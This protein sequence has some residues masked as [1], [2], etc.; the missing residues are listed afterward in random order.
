MIHSVHISKIIEAWKV[1]EKRPISCLFHFWYWNS[2]YHDT[3]IVDWELQSIMIQSVYEYKFKVIKV[4]LLSYVFT[5]IVSWYFQC[6]SQ[7]WLYHD[8]MS[9][10]IKIERSM[11]W[12]FSL[13]PSMPLSFWICALIVS[14]Y[15]QA[16]NQHWKY[17][18]TIKGKTLNTIFK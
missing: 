11:K 3:I 5:L 1:Q 4:I 10:I 15:F 17:H 13:A 12:V 16:L 9:F 18:A 6:L 8:T 2:L 14:W 7:L